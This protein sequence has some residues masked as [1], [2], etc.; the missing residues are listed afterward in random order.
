MRLEADIP[1]E[2][3]LMLLTDSGTILPFQNDSSNG[4]FRQ[5]RALRGCATGI[6]GR[7]KIGRL[8]TGSFH[9]PNCEN[10][11]ARHLSR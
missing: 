4:S 1:S 9:T 10:E 2:Q 11:R 3:Q 6:A 8:R 5:E 7:Q